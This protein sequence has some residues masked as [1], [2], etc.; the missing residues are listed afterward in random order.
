VNQL[1]VDQQLNPVFKIGI[2]LL[3]LGAIVLLISVVREKLMVK[4][5]DKY[6]EVE[7]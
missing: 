5:V 7:R 1:L 3:L 4:K 2:L 6:R